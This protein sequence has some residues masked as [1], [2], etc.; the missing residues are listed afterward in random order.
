M[1]ILLNKL[2]RIT[3][4]ALQF[5]IKSEICDFIEL[6]FSLNDSN[7]IIID[8]D[9]ELYETLI[10]QLKN[11]NQYV[12]ILHMANKIVKPMERVYWLA[13]P[14]KVEPLKKL[15]IQ[16]NKEMLKEGN[17]AK[18]KLS[19]KKKQ[20][21][22]AKAQTQSQSQSQK[23]KQTTTKN[24][25]KNSHLYLAVNKKESDQELQNRYKA[26]KYVGSNKNI[27]PDNPEEL[28]LIYHTSKKYL[29]YHLVKALNLANKNKSDVNIKTVFGSILYDNANKQFL[30]G[31][32]ENK[33]KFV[34]S[35]PLFETTKLSLIQIKNHLSI[36]KTEK[37]DATKLIWESAI[38]ASKGRLPNDTDLNKI[39]SMKCWP[40]FSKVK[41]FRYAIQISAVWATTSLSLLQTA[42]QLKIPQRYVFTLYCAMNA[43]QCANTNDNLDKSNQEIKSKKRSIFSKLLTH[44]FNKKN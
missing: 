25:N 10:E 18:K 19:D 22:L 40:N 32:D 7:L 13:N 28:R 1:K 15:L 2:D 21:I 4:N 20:Q 6:S 9:I 31:F 24:S 34:K 5:F 26:H 42:N 3:T 35:N 30:Y 23:N 27:N 39:V 12:L 11:N 36:N 14:L 41:I 43:I 16:I 33:I 37:V 44:V 38:Y 29:Y 8:S 17:S